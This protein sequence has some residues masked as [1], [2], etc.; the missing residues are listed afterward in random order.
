MLAWLSS[1]LVDILLV[2]ALA[3]ILGLIVRKLLR[4]RKAGKCACGGNCAHC[5][6]GGACHRH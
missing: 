3:A 6:M 5:S 2:L 4:D 1:H